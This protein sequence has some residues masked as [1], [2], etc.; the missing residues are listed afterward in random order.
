[1]DTTVNYYALVAAAGAA[2]AIGV[3]WYGPLFGTMWKRMS[4][5]NDT[6]AQATM[7]KPW[8]AMLGGLLNTLVIAYVLTF[9]IVPWAGTLREALLTVFWIWLGFVATAQISGFL[10]EGKSFRLFLVHTGY[11]L[12]IYGVMASILVLWR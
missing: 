11:S 7:L 12:V 1:M 6:A 5:L 10:W 9:F 2:L 4:G 3:L 8:Q